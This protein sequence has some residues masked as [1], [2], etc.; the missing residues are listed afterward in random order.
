MV[1]QKELYCGVP[2]VTLWRVLRKCLNFQAC[3]L[4]AVQGW[5]ACTSLS[6][7]VFLTLATQQYLEYHCKPLFE[8]PCIEVVLTSSKI[9]NV[10]N[11]FSSFIILSLALTQ[12]MLLYV[13]LISTACVLFLTRLR[14]CSRYPSHLPWLH[15]PLSM[16]SFCSVQTYHLWPMTQQV[17]VTLSRSTC[18][19]H[20][21]GSEMQ[22]ASTS[23]L[24]AGTG[25]LQYFNK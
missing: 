4:S 7:N 24:V 21:Q 6:V 12:Q 15:V 11:V 16:L 20:L 5:I 25:K 1:F 17:S 19:C 3:K 23:P 18:K 8:T 14:D 13:I 9:P 10:F 22:P 2:N